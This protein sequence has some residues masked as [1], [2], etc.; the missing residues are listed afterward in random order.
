MHE[1]FKSLFGHVCLRDDRSSISSRGILGTF[2]SDT[3]L[4]KCWR[5]IIYN[6]VSPLDEGNCLDLS[7][8]SLQLVDIEPFNCSGE[9]QCFC[10][11]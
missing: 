11:V 8:V 7:W 6:F 2:K 3:I 4:N 9:E 5:Y 1:G 10:K